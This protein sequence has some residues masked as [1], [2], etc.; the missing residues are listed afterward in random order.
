M[1]SS[2]YPLTLATFLASASERNAENKKKIYI[3]IGIMCIRVTRRLFLI[4]AS[5]GAHP[6]YISLEALTADTNLQLLLEQSE[7]GLC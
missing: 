2:L 7:E 4:A 5:A 6:V 1:M 3:H